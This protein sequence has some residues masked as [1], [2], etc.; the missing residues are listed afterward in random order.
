MEEMRP[1]VRLGSVGACGKSAAAHQRKG[2]M[3][4]VPM[5]KTVLSCGVA[6]ALWLSATA[7]WAQQRTFD[8]PA[9]DAATAIPEFARQAGLQIVAPVG[10]L[11]SVRTPA[12][13]GS[14]DAREALK[15]LL[16]GTGLEIATDDGRVIS[17]RRQG[18]A[19]STPAVTGKLGAA[20]SNS[21]SGS[22]QR[23]EDQ[24]QSGTPQDSPKVEEIPS[25]AASV[26]S[27]EV[28]EMPTMIVT[29][30]H[31]RNAA[32]IGSPLTVFERRE[33]EQS[34]SATLA[35]FIRQIPQNLGS[36]DS[37]AALNFAPSSAGLPQG[38]ANSYFGSGFNLRGLGAGATLVLLNG[39]RLSGAGDDAAFVDVSMI[40][41]SAIDR[42]ELMTD[43]ASAVYGA[44]AI[45]GVVNI[46]LRQDF[47]GAETSLRY[48]DT[49]RGGADQ[50]SM[51]QLLGT[52][53]PSGNA[54]LVYRHEKQNPM[55]ST[56]RDFIP[57]QPIP[58]YVV[59]YRS[60]DSVIV[61][62]RQD[63][64]GDVMATGSIVFSD[65]D[66]VADQFGGLDETGTTALTRRTKGGAQ[67]RGT[68]LSLSRTPSDMWH[69]A[70]DLNYSS[71]RQ[72]S[73]TNIVNSPDDP[74]RFSGNSSIASVDAHGDGT[75]FTLPAGPAKAAL[76]IGHRKEKLNG[77]GALYG[78]G[79][80]RNV[81]SAYAEVAVPLVGPSNSRP[82]VQKLDLS[83]ALRHDRYS[84]FGSSTNPKVGLAWRPAVRSR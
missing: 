2:S 26:T 80:S 58:Q 19:G 6:A 43:G 15:L 29:G 37:S 54:M 44:D 65:R 36:I 4:A 7:A 28:T 13:K 41:V 48:S 1:A 62:A 83:V 34:G 35:E 23:V 79:L 74:Q 75:V 61:T 53:W 45:A 77:A 71:M 8:V 39:Q 69:M 76:G 73:A 51:T 21:D 66:Y 68:S 42:V 18:A 70:V 49:S 63:F 24:S 82:G 57:E 9:Q 11:K 17:L 50:F 47:E 40:P 33:I 56:Q 30:T 10:H 55:L 14:L 25:G 22:S 20:I 52:D 78:D 64:G 46:V 16:R 32:P 27:S 84:D 31:I 38:G 60:G 3:M 59:P 72:D 12:V 67:Q 5:R 81:S